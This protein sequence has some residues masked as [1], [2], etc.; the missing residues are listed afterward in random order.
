MATPAA[1]RETVAHLVE[2]YEMSERRACRLTRADRKTVRYRSRRPRDE[3]L[4]RRLRELA[5]EQRR[6]GHRRLHVPLHA[7]GHW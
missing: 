6:F 1:K 2:T 7:E 3:E 4:R 5:A